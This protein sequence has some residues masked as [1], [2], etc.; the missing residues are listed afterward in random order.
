LSRQR[1]AQRLF[2]GL[3]GGVAQ[4]VRVLLALGDR[5]GGGWSVEVFVEFGRCLA[6]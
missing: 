2:Y 5:R 4:Q 6:A 1:G 3:D